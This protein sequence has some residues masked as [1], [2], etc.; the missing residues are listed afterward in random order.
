[1]PPTSVTLVQHQTKMF[2]GFK[3]P[4]SNPPWAFTYLNG[5]RSH[6]IKA[7]HVLQLGNNVNLSPAEKA[8]DISAK[9]RSSKLM[10]RVH[11]MMY[12]TSRIYTFKGVRSTGLQFIRTRVKIL[13]TLFLFEV[14]IYW[15]LYLLH[16]YLP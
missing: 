9:G 6:P 14:I 16:T 10:F 13:S 8:H 4:T 1:M 3:Q 7:E 5:C 15:L 2:V 12:L 11:N